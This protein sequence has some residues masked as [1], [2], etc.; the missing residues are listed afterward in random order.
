MYCAVHTGEAYPLDKAET[1]ITRHHKF[2]CITE[3]AKNHWVYVL[4]VSKLRKLFSGPMRKS[5]H[6]D[7]NYI[8][9]PSFLVILHLRSTVLL[10]RFQ[11]SPRALKST[12]QDSVADVVNGA[13]FH[14]SR[15][16]QIVLFDTLL[17]IWY[18]F[19]MVK[20]WKVPKQL[21]FRS[22]SLYCIKCFTF[23]R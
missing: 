12:E 1:N 18:S 7:F 23:I 9:A 4:P 16:W 22:I 13:S 10:S 20:D 3:E 8:Q 17:H 14:K 11:S 5:L 21:V 6:G 2:C 15:A 19:Q